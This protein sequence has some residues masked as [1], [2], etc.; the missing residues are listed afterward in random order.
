MV[1]S[2]ILKIRVLLTAQRNVVITYKGVATV[3]NKALQVQECDARVPNNIVTARH[4]KKFSITAE[5]YTL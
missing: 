1:A 3:L 2:L 5:G 4:L